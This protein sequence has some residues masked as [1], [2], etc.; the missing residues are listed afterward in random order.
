MNTNYSFNVKKKRPE[1]EYEKVSDYFRGDV[2]N[3]YA[4]SKNM[5]RIQQKI[6]NRALELLNFKN[7]GIL[8]LD[9]GCGPGFAG[10]YLK[11]MGFRIVA[12]D[13]IA[14]FLY[15]Y[16]INEINPINS[17]MCF[18]PF[19]SN[20]FDAIISISAL[21]W[22]YRDINNKMMHFML[23]N[24][25]KSF[26]RILKSNSKVVMQFYPKNKEIMERI[27]KIVSEHTDFKGQFII[28]NPNSHK[29]RRIFLLLNK[30]S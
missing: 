18:P 29:K 14:E 2:L 16:E 15:F 10:I 24:L 27:G 19:K 6:T 21:Q 28:D 20:I 22:I 7:R 3:H 17:D 30:K 9:A 23:V 1:E 5:M 8:I 26:F 12:L 25:F 13:L 4:T 11:E